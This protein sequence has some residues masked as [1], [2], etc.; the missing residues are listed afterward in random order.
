MSHDLGEVW[1]V[2][3]STIQ[4]SLNRLSLCDAEEEGMHKIKDVKCQLLC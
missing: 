2:I 4:V 3:H 1:Q